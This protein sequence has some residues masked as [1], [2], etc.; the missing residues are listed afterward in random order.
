MFPVIAVYD[1]GDK[2]LNLKLFK[3]HIITQDVPLS[4]SISSFSNSDVLRMHLIV[5]FREKCE[6]IFSFPL[7]ESFS[8]SLNSS[9]NKFSFQD[10]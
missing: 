5:F 9:P 8:D 4:V 1:C 6:L 2:F 3:V 10:R 7:F